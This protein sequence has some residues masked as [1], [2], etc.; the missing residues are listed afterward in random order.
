MNGI[1]T[2]GY[3]LIM[4]KNMVQMVLTGESCISSKI[5]IST[6]LDQHH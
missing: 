2:S 1:C 6:L 4:R 5:K 3:Q